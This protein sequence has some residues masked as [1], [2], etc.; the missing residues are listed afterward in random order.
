MQSSI[1]IKSILTGRILT[2][3]SGMSSM[4]ASVR[5]I[6]VDLGCIILEKGIGTLRG[7]P[8]FF[9]TDQDT[10]SSAMAMS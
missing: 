6:I 4:F 9:P 5:L 1:S 2:E 8:C 7:R 3:L 10:S